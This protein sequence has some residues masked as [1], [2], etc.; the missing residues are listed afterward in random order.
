MTV[1]IA[2][3]FFSE[4]DVGPWI[5]FSGFVLTMGAIARVIWLR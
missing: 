1:G 2:T 3:M 5:A 4:G